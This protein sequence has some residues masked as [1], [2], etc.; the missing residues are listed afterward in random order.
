MGIAIAILT[1]FF[2]VGWHSRTGPLAPLEKSDR[3]MVVSAD[4]PAAI[5][6]LR[7]RGHEI[8][9]RDGWGNVNAIVVMPDSQLQGAADP[10][11]DG[12][13]VGF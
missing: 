11:G 1:T 13:A 6:A 4:P 5:E 3:S 2:T 7:R 10:R 9:E 8:I 12:A